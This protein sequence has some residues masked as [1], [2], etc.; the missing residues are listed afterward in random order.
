MIK[1]KM[2]KQKH[3]ESHSL[4]VK[5]DLFPKINSL[6]YKFYGQFERDPLLDAEDEVGTK[7]IS[8]NSSL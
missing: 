6:S 4:D 2:E 8:Q 5:A 7:P 1:K 3:E